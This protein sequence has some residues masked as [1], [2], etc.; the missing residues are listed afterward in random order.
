MSR[1]VA[2]H[3]FGMFVVAVVFGGLLVWFEEVL[4]ESRVEPIGIKLREWLIDFRSWGAFGIGMSLITG[5]LWYVFA[6]R[7]L[8]DRVKDTKRRGI[9]VLGFVPPLLSAI[10]AVLFSKPAQEGALIAYVFY[11]INSLAVYYFGT[12]FCSPLAFKYT[13]WGAQRLRFWG[14]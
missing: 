11:F 6:Q 7:K 8:I 3:I 10:A 14:R 2:L 5:V 12:A 1:K 4:V 13:P 9:W